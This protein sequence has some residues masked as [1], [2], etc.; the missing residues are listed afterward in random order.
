MKRKIGILGLSVFI[1]LSSIFS[2]SAAWEHQEGIWKYQESDSSYA[3]NKWLKI[4]NLWYHFDDK[5][6]MQTGW[7]QTGDGKWYYLDKEN[8][9]MWVNKRTPDGYYVDESGVYDASKGQFTKEMLKIGP[10]AQIVEEKEKALLKGVEFPS[11]SSFAS[12]NLTTGDWGIAGSQEAMSSLGNAMQNSIQIE[13]NVITYAP[14]GTVKMKLVKAGDHYEI[15]DYGSIDSDM[16]TILM[17]MSC[18][19]SSK[20]HSIFNAI[21]TASEY[22]QTIMRSSYYKKFGDVKIMYTICDGYISF[23]VAAK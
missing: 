19:I 10:G 6:D 11:L 14:G 8:G 3:T 18:L 20:P 7:F 4:N 5:G 9:D 2:A 16:E 23:S 22:D 15:H 17:A 12:S 13:G 1:S 21:Y